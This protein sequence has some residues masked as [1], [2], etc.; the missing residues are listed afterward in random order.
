[1]GTI[2][3]ALEKHKKEKS[4]KTQMLP[5]RKPEDSVPDER[6]VSPPRKSKIPEGFDPKLIVGVAPES[7]DAENFKILRARIIFPKDGKQPKTIMVTSA[8][9]GEGKT[10]VAANL[11]ASLAQGIDEYVLL[12]DCDLRRPAVHSMYGYSNREGLREYLTGKRQLS[13]L[14]LKTKI[15]KL[16]LLT[17]GRLPPNPSEL[18]SSDMM[19]GFLEEVKGRYEDRYIIIDS[20]PSQFASEANVLAKRVDGIIFVI[21]SGKSPRKEIY[22][23]IENLGKEKVLGIVFNGY[24]HSHRYYRKYDKEYKYYR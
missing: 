24:S 23:G 9:P 10:F 7:Y 13:D 6:K 8:F 17:A 21:M 3:D 1:M 16:S 20:P 22:R 4:I 2:S 12:I 19:K 5:R 14:F 18:L 15:N 11:A